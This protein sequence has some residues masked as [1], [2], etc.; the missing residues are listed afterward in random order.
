MNDLLAALLGGGTIG[1]AITAYF[2]HVAKRGE[3]QSQM[4]KVA[5]TEIR[6]ELKVVREE[7]AQL[8]AEIKLK[9]ERIDGLVAENISL[10]YE[11]REKDREIQNLKG[12]S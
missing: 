10:K 4:D 11:I 8:R 9:D 3:T 2:N 7:V 12:G 5:F 1:I 6:E